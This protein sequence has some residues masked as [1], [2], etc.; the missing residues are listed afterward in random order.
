M[1][2]VQYEVQYRVQ[3][4]QRTV[5]GVVQ[6]AVLGVVQGAVLGVVQGTV[7][8][9]RTMYKL[10]LHG[11]SVGEADDGS[12]PVRLAH[13]TDKGMRE[14][15]GLPLHQMLD[16]IPAADVD[17]SPDTD[18]DPSHVDPSGVWGGR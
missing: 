6:G 18:V 16:R 15:V 13:E 12:M 17:P 10:E 7:R 9:K 3:Y 8:H 5:Q 14:W 4:R 2:R 1:C 11:S